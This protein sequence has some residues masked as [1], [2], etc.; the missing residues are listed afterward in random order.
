[1]FCQVD[2]VF[3]SVFILVEQFFLSM[4]I[5]DLTFYLIR[6]GFDL[7]VTSSC[8]MSDSRGVTRKTRRIMSTTTGISRI[9]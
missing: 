8:K 5:F 6:D 4:S 9:L 3:D 1:M 7:L 2:L